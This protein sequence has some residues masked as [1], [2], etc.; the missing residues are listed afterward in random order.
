MV[1]EEFRSVIAIE[2]EQGERQRLFDMVDLLD[3]AEFSLSPDRSL[4]APAGSDIHTVNGVGEHPRQGLS[5]VGH[6]IGFEKTGARFIPLVGVDGDMFFQQGS[7][8]GGGSASFSVLD[9]HRAQ[10]PVHGC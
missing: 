7:W 9:P 3:N 4:F 2:S 6:G 5:A 10:Q 1:V 8:F